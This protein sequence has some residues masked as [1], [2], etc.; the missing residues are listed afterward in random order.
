MLLKGISKGA[1]IA[2]IELYDPYEPYIVSVVV[3]GEELRVVDS[4]CAQY[5]VQDRVEILPI[6]TFAWTWCCRGT[7]DDKC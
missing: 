1:D 3:C 4:G 5:R 7:T 2:L 6:G